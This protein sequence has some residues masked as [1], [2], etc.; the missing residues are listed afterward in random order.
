MYNTA[1]NLED[2]DIIEELLSFDT[3]CGIEEH[4]QIFEERFKDADYRIDVRDFSEVDKIKALLLPLGYE[5]YLVDDEDTVVKISNEANKKVTEEITWIPFDDVTEDGC[6]IVQ[7][8]SHTEGVCVPMVEFFRDE[9][10][11]PPHTMRYGKP[12]Y[13]AKFPQGPKQDI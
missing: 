2:L 9:S 1:D 11:W 5:A 3:V 8:L 7:F 10:G 6:Y 13:A 12:T 4:H